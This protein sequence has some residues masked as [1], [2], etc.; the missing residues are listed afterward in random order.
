[1]TENCKAKELVEKLMN[2]DLNE[3]LSRKDALDEPFIT[4]EIK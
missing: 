1:M 3:R 2:P 4:K